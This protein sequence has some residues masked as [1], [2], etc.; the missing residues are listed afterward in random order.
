MS[1]TAPS[2]LKSGRLVL[3]LAAPTLARLDELSRQQGLKFGEIIRQ[4]LAI[5]SHIVEARRQNPKT[6]VLIDRGDG[7]P[8]EL[9]LPI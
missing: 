3:T 7:K 2:A 4:A 1:L 6:R 5:Y 8:S 9:V